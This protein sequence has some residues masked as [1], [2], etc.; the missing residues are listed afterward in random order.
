MGIRLLAGGVA[1]AA[2]ALVFGSAAAAH[3]TPQAGYDAVLKEQ[4]HGVLATSTAF[5]KDCGEFGGSVGA[6]KEGWVFNVPSGQWDQAVGLKVVFTPAGGGADVTI[7]I[8][9]DSP[10][11]D[12]YPQGFGP[13]ANPHN[14]WVQVPAGWTLKDA[15][16]KTLGKKTLFLVTHTCLKAVSETPKP[17]QSPTPSVSATPPASTPTPPA[18]P[19][20]GGD[21]PK[22][23]FPV[24]GFVVAGLALLA[25]GA[26][27]LF[28]RRRRELPSEV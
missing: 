26:A 5:G 23:G 21:L 16:G 25:G 15:D 3:E 14:A 22:T 9:T 28:V 6:G 8:K 17:S 11:K 24:T 1:A 13:K 18:T 20:E 10:D 19:D 7:L 4:H 27:L 2:A 12:T